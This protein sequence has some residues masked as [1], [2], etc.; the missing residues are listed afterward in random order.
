MVINRRRF[1]KLSGLVPMVGVAGLAG[2]ISQRRERAILDI[3]SNPPTYALWGYT[4]NNE[5]GKW[6]PD[7]NSTITEMWEKCPKDL[8]YPLLWGNQK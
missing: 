1:L 8:E 3:E 2:A 5:T 4:K 7:G 6:E